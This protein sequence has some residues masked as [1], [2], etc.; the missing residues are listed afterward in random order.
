[1]NFTFRLLAATGILALTAAA[2]VACPACMSADPKTADTYLG[3]TLMM[4]A[5]PLGLVGG[6]AYWLWRRYS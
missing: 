3:M 2:A 6:L 1:M 5:L 4:S